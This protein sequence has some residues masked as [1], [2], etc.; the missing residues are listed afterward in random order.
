MMGAV[1]A[2][3]TTTTTI[4]VAAAADAGTRIAFG[5]GSLTIAMVA[6][7]VIRPGFD[8]GPNGWVYATS[9]DCSC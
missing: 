8:G 4:L 7:V 3:G 9:L 2:A 6:M 5:A 1:V